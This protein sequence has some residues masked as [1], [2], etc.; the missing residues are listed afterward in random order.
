MG[1]EGGMEGAW[2]IAGHTMTLSSKNVIEIGSFLSPPSSAFYLP[3]SLLS[4]SFLLLP[5]LFSFSPLSPPPPSSLDSCSDALSSE[6]QLDFTRTMNRILFDKTV[7]T[8]P[9]TFPFVTLPDP[10]IETV[11]QR[12]GCIVL[13]VVIPGCVE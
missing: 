2:H 1:G 10:H 8:K 5:L 3:S 13:C 7:T 6:L 4:L 9:G 12:G 11:P